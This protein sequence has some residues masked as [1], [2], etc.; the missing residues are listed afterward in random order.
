MEG[1]QRVNRQKV[2]E[3]K[4]HCPVGVVFLCKNN[5]LKSVSSPLITKRN[6]IQGFPFLSTELLDRV[7]FPLAW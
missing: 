7:A 1:P 6:V 5:A 4:S 3:A 2:K